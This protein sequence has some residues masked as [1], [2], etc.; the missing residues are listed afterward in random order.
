MRDVPP[1]LLWF[2]SPWTHD[3][4][5]SAF[6]LAEKAAPVGWVSGTRLS[7]SFPASSGMAPACLPGIFKLWSLPDIGFLQCCWPLSHCT[8]CLE[9]K[10]VRYPSEERGGS[11]PIVTQTFL[12][13]PC[14]TIV[15]ESTWQL[16]LLASASKTKA[17]PRVGLYYEAF[18]ASTS[19]DVSHQQSGTADQ[20]ENTLLLTSSSPDLPMWQVTDRSVWRRAPAHM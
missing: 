7:S 19:S 17:K 18:L 11:F 5:C 9:T 14:A 3:G 8:S 13:A 12:P 16:N 10:W 1:P 20:E 2:W 6:L 15:E 4:V